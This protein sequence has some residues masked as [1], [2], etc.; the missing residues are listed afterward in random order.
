MRSRAPE[1]LILSFKVAIGCGVHIVS[2]QARSFSFTRNTAAGTGLSVSSPFSVAALSASRTG[3]DADSARALPLS[4]NESVH[5]H[6]R[7]KRVARLLGHAGND[8]AAIGVADQHDVLE[9]FPLD[10]VDDVG[11]V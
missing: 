4:R 5:E 2:T 10:H 3:C 1:M 9:P 7:C 11:D 8:D 6:D